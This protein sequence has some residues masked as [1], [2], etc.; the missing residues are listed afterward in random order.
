MRILADSAVLND[1]VIESVVERVPVIEPGRIPRR[2]HSIIERVGVVP[3]VVRE[4]SV[5]IIHIRV[6]R[7][8]LGLIRLSWLL[9]RVSDETK[10]GQPCE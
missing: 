9:K 2:P 6:G 5:G 4:V 1:A 8:R 10:H 7:D 3:K